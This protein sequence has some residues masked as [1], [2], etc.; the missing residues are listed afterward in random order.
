MIDLVISQ[1]L[2]YP[3]NNPQDQIMMS[4]ED[5]IMLQHANRVTLNGGNILEIGFGLGISANYIQ[6]NNIDSHTIV[7]IHPQIASL[8]REW[9]KDKPNV[10]I[11]EDDWMT[12]LQQ[13][14]LKKYDGIFHDTH[15]ILD[16]NF[17]L[18]YDSVKDFANPN[19]IFSYFHP[20]GFDLYKVGKEN[21]NY[22]TVQVTVPE[23]CTYFKGKV[24]KCPWFLIP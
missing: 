24:A 18:F 7:E 19:C 2:I 8:A 4:W 3:V 11:I 22:D 10:T 12:S 21:L 15:P 6:Q 1:D 20:R 16:P 5:P 9:A 23:E 13:I 14:G 17:R